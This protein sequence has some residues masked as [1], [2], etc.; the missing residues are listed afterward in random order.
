MRGPDECTV[1][2]GRPAER[3]E[4]SYGGQF[5]CCAKRTFDTYNNAPNIV[6][7]I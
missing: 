2:T 7:V 4:Q 6:L 5:P 1:H 3:D